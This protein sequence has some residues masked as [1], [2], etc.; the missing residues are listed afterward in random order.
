MSYPILSNK[1]SK[2]TLEEALILDPE[3]LSIARDPETIYYF[4][5]D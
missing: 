1:R 4:D 2:M 5:K 3:G